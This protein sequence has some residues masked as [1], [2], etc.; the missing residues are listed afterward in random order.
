MDTRWLADKLG[1]ASQT[2]DTTACAQH[3]LY[4]TVSKIKAVAASPKVPSE[5]MRVTTLSTD[6]AT[7]N[8]HARLCKANAVKEVLQALLSDVQRALGIEVVDEDVTKKRRLRAKDHEGAAT[9][10]AKPSVNDQ[11]MNRSLVK[12]TL[13]D[14]SDDEGDGVARLDTGESKGNL[15]HYKDQLASSDEDD[16]ASDDED[17]DVGDL[18]RQLASEGIGKSKYSR[19]P[20]S[21]DH[22]ADLSLSDAGPPSNSPSPEPEKVGSTS[23]EAFRPSLAM[24]GY[25]SGSGSEIDDDI[26]V[27]PKKNRRGQRARQQ[28]AEKR[29]GSKAKHLQK[30][31]APKRNEGWD[32]KRGAIEGSEG[33][34]GGR[35][36]ATERS[37]PRDKFSNVRAPA[38]AGV[39]GPGGDAPTKKHRDDSGP[40]HPSWEAAKKAKER[41]DAP[42]AFQ[43]K[44]ITFD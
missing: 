38:V 30:Q 44:K 40:I 16:G 25:I 21:Y 12:G 31:Q 11:K 6:P 24:S 39:R 36:P 28:L 33:R 37:K 2:L 26:D 17:V 27:A 29:F 18:E 4:K 13:F 5:V 35:R 23:R 9:I 19:P 32:A 3:H 8:V 1:S 22:A 10:A 42:V 7:L 14:E 20:K 43:G 34:H 41:K 15:D